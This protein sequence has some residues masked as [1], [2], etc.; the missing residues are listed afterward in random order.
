MEGLPILQTIPSIE[1][2]TV[3]NKG[4]NCVNHI[5]IICGPSNFILERRQFFYHPSFPI[6][7]LELLQQY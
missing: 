6:A 3:L 4:T 1:M 7:H 2:V 5:L